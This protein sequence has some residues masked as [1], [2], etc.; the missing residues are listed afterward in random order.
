MSSKSIPSPS[1]STRSREPNSDSN[2]SFVGAKTV[3]S[4]SGSVSAFTMPV[5]VTASTKIAARAYVGQNDGSQSAGNSG[6]VVRVDHD[7][8][9]RDVQRSGAPDAM[10]AT[11]SAWAT[12]AAARTISAIVTA[13][14][15]IFA[16]VSLLLLLLLFLFLL[17]CV[18]YSVID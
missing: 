5:E 3:I 13:L 9:G 15:K 18:Q 8:G 7:H 12:N 4:D 16:I 11:E 6:V 1:L 2:A 17:L 10:V 14:V